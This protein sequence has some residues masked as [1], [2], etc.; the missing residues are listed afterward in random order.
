MTTT[1]VDTAIIGGGQAGLAIGHYLAR[2]G[3]D[4]AILDANARTGDAWR[5]RWDSLRLFTPAKYDGLPGMRFP[6]DPLAFPTKDEQ[7][8]YLES[9]AE[10]FGLPVSR[11]VRVSGLSRPDG[12]FV[13]DS[14]DRSWTARQ[15]VLATGSFGTPRIPVFAGDLDATVTQL[16]S[17]QYRNPGQ[18]KPGPTLVVGGGNSGAEIALELSRSHPTTLAA[19]PGVEIP[20]RHGRTFARYG[21]PVIRFAGA[22]V[23]NERSLIG[24][25]VLPKMRE[26][27]TPLIRTKSANLTAAG[28]TRVGRVAEVREGR[29]VT[30]D[31]DILDMANVI[32]CTGYRADY[33]W[34]DLPHLTGNGE[35]PHRR[36]V[37]EST[38]GLFLLGQEFLF[39]VLSETLAGLA[40]DARYLAACLLG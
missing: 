18:L 5:S 28:V 1:T 27:A 4:F 32:W 31:G 8:D 20:F 35:P 38:P 29:C 12:S 17:S 2:A 9:Y 37:V 26:Q 24:R 22:H 30:E 21:L 36:G 25:R 39:S 14:A 23:L 34:I 16:H 11:S 13:I 19:R 40:R 15:V 3:H 33:S 7:A 6:A 10:R